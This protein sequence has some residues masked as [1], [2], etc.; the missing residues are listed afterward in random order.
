MQGK[1][2]LFLTIA[3]W[4]KTPQDQQAQQKLAGIL[5]I[6]SMYQGRLSLAFK[7]LCQNQSKRYS[8]YNHWLI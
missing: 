7:R 2:F 1:V 4:D 6:L 8:H 5:L 3:K